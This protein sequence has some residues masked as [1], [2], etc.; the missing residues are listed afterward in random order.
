MGHLSTLPPNVL[1]ATGEAT[2]KNLQKSELRIET[3]YLYRCLIIIARRAPARAKAG[4]GLWQ[5]GR[6]KTAQGGF[7]GMEVG[8]QLSEWQ[9]RPQE[10]PAAGSDICNI[11]ADRQHNDNSPESRL[12]LIVAASKRAALCDG[13]ASCTRGCVAEGGREAIFRG[14]ADRE[15][16][17]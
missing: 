14:A 15:L 8:A 2:T 7:P 12:N 11:R 10:A 1:P 6:A 17:L 5:F 16:S 3:F 13:R 4:L 9:R